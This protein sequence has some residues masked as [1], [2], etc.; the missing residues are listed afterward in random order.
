MVDD[1][2]FV[3]NAVRRVLRAHDVDV[4]IGGDEAARRLQA[5]ARYDVVLCDLMMPGM[6]G[7]GLYDHIRSRF[8]ELVS[9]MVF[10]TGGAFTERA[11]SFVERVEPFLIHKP[12]DAVTLRDAVARAAEA[13]PV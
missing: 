2:A 11:R 7:P 10:M 3:A 12:F 6:D 8:P 1:E 5:S 9:H 4:A 13:L